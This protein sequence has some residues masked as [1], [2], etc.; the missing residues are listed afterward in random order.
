MLTDTKSETITRLVDYRKW[1]SWQ[2]CLRSRED[3]AFAILFVFDVPTLTFNTQEMQRNA[4]RTGRFHLIT[5]TIALTSFWISCDSQSPQQQN[6]HLDLEM[7]RAVK[8][9]YCRN[10]LSVCIENRFLT[11][12]QQLYLMFLKF[13]SVLRCKIQHSASGFQNW[14]DVKSL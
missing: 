9:G 10:F 14:N 12:S 5:H 13:R 11:A 3:K 4:K 2:T 1:D 8:W 6:S 7:L